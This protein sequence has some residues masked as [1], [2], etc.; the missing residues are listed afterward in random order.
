MHESTKEIVDTE[1]KRRRQGL[2]E[3]RVEEGNLRTNIGSSSSG[4]RDNESEE[5]E[6]VHCKDMDWREGGQQRESAVKN[7]RVR[8][9]WV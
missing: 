5:C 7:G 8:G 1:R 4:A 6:G 3:P 9:T 2:K